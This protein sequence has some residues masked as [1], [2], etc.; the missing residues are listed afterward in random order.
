MTSDRKKHGWSWIIA[1]VIAVLVLYVASFGPAN[2][3]FSKAGQP[4]WGMEV[5]ESVYFPLRCVIDDG[6]EWLSDALCSY[7]NW[8]LESGLE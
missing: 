6:P 3:A 8:G 5:L 1:T 7:G 4:P 2:W